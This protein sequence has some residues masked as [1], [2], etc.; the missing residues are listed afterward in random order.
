MKDISDNIVTFPEKSIIFRENEFSKDLY[1]LKSGKVHLFKK[2]GTKNILLTEV[3]PG[4]I[5]GELSIM[6]GGPRSATA[7]AYK[8]TKAVKITPVEFMEGLKNIPE[9]ILSIAR[10]LA[11][12]L[13]A[14]DK[15]LALKGPIVNETN[16]SAILT[17]LLNGAED[18]SE[19]LLI[20]E[21]E[22][23]ILELLHIS[24]NELQEVFDTL[25]KKKLIYIKQNK[26]GSD[27]IPL[28]EDHLSKIRRS[29]STTMVI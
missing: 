5:L 14:S 16:V 28:L 8:E 17:Y 25:I 29:L 6:D 22:N 27:S 20:Q 19:G 11:K 26:I 12:R 4:G 2:I 3:N 1:I 23:N 24:I 7:V 15:K 18:R 13:R 21:V 10:V 9:W